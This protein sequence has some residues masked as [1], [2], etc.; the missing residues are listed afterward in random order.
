MT[1]QDRFNRAYRAHA[2]QT[3]SPGRADGWEALRAA[4]ERFARTHGLTL[5]APEEPR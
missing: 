5:P 3:E 4:L 1:L 2:S